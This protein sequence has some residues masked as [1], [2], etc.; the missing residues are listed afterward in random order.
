MRYGLLIICSC[1]HLKQYNSQG[2]VVGSILPEMSKGAKLNVW[3]F[4]TVEVS[5]LTKELAHNITKV[6]VPK[7]V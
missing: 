7:V 5:G 4:K 1:D 2:S 6:L 3:F